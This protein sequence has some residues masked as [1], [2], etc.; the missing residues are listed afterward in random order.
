M[1]IK[2]EVGEIVR[3]Q[4]N[5]NKTENSGIT[6][7]MKLVDSVDISH[8]RVNRVWSGDDSK[9]MDID[10]ANKVLNALGFRLEVVVID[11]KLSFE[12]SESMSQYKVDVIVLNMKYKG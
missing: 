9:S 6:G 12:S 4:V 10:D 5:H 3:S 2:R 11:E 8:P 1:S 7:I